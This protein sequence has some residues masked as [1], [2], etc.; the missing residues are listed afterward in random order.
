[1]QYNM[2]LKKCF[3]LRIILFY[4]IIIIISSLS[5]YKDTPLKFLKTYGEYYKLFNIFY[6]TTKKNIKYSNESKNTDISYDYQIR[7][8][9]E[10]YNKWKLERKFED[11]EYTYKYKTSFHNLPNN[12][13][14]D[15]LYYND[16]YRYGIQHDDRF[17]NIVFNS[18]PWIHNK[19]DIYF[20]GYDVNLHKKYEKIYCIFT[21]PIPMNIKAWMNH[22][23]YLDPIG[24]PTPESVIYCTIP[25]EIINILHNKSNLIESITF[26]LSGITFYPA[27]KIQFLTNVTLYEPHILDY[28]NH[29]N[30]TLS[31]MVDS[32]NDVMLLEWVIYNILLG[33]EHFYLYDNSKQHPSLMYKSILKPFFDANI[34]TYIYFPAFSD[35]FWS[36][37]QRVAMNIYL[38]Q[39]GSLTSWWGM[40]DID[41]FFLPSN[42]FRKKYQYKVSNDDSILDLLLNKIAS[43]N[44]EISPQLVP[45][46]M[47]DTIEMG[48]DFANNS[49]KR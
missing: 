36:H 14:N 32:I 5:Y 45:A 7:N 46:I 48:C 28:E 1:M 39:F 4:N 8:Y 22:D 11:I 17:F 43:H 29:Y 47:F 18:N 40:Y 26:H 10:D 13:I 23:D 27:Q 2:F 21:Y 19:S 44:N 33:V 42:Y 35:I 30:I 12:S 16:R 15:I 25:I 24:Q 37:V 9:K 20:I 38:N 49:Y 41:E 34:I 3:F 31:F 6:N